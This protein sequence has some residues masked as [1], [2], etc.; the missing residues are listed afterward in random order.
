MSGKGSNTCGLVFG[1]PNALS[2]CVLLSA[3]SAN[4]LSKCFLTTGLVNE[5]ISSKSILIE[6]YVS[7][8][9]SLTSLVGCLLRNCDAIRGAHVCQSP[10][11]LTMLIEPRVPLGLIDVPNGFVGLAVNGFNTLVGSV[12]NFLFVLNMMSLPG[13]RSSEYTAIPFK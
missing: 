2:W 7:S 9:L 12:P 13:G 1:V 4:L 10:S 3:P 8:S 5:L 11:S 6:S